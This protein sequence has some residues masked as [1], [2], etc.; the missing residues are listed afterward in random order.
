MSH[1]LDMQIEQKMYKY[2]GGFKRF[3]AAM[4]TH[5]YNYYSNASTSSY[6]WEDLDCPKIYCH[7]CGYL[8]YCEVQELFCNNCSSDLSR[9]K[10]SDLIVSLLPV[11]TIFLALL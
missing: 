11:L 1:Y 3:S 5:H 4:V 7:H 6:A 9:S 10:V 2:G 8:N